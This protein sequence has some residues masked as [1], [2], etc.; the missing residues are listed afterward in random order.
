MSIPV[1]ILI[2]AGVLFLVLLLGLIKKLAGSALDEVMQ[3]YP[4]HTH[5]QICPMANMFGLKS[6]GMKQVRGNG[7]LLLTNSVLY[8]RMLMPRREVLV[9]VSSITGFGVEKSFLGKT[10]GVKLLRIDFTPETGGADSAAWIVRDLDG[11]LSSLASLTGLRA[12]P[13]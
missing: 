13:S 9:P 7:I 1:I 3:T 6:R 12:Q 8:F 4:A 10:K 2:L 11:W 5:L